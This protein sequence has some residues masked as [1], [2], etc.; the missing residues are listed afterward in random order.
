MLYSTVPNTIPHKGM[1][2]LPYK[3]S[4]YF[5]TYNNSGRKTYFDHF[6]LTNMCDM[7]GTGLQKE[8]MKDKVFVISALEEFSVRGG[9]ERQIN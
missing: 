8:R 3:I 6:H 9:G 5:P 1:L 7:P 4:L 2:A